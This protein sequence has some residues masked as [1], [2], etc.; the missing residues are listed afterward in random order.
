MHIKKEHQAFAMQLGN[1]GSKR[2]DLD[3]DSDNSSDNDSADTSMEGGPRTQGMS[4]QTVLQLKR[5]ESVSGSKDLLAENNCIDSMEEPEKSKSF[6]AA[7]AEEAKKTTGDSK[8]P[9]EI[10]NKDD[11][12][13]GT[14]NDNGSGSSSSSSSSSDLSSSSSVD[15]D[16][17]NT[18]AVEVNLPVKVS[19]DSMKESKA[20]KQRRNRWCQ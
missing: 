18:P 6:P 7:I 9:V 13:V 2:V 4:I 1:V 16:E 5:D 10:D 20:G 12:L 3:E 15:D 19:T 8:V 11:L 17:G 14:D